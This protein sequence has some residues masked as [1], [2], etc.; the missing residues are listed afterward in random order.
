MDGGAAVK[1]RPVAYAL[2]VFALVLL[3][4]GVVKGVAGVTTGKG[5]VLSCG[6]AIRPQHFERTSKTEVVGGVPVDG[7]KISFE[8]DTVVPRTDKYGL[9]FSESVPT[10]PMSTRVV[11]VPSL[12]ETLCSPVVGT[13]RAGTTTYLGVAAIA[14]IGCLVAHGAARRAETRSQTATL[15]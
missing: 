13:V 9:S 15:I 3:F 8:S 6:S 10:T 14:A 7:S 2:G 4:Y 1:P 11:L 5:G 12:A